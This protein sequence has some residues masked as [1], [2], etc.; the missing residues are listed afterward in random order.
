MKLPELDNPQRYEGLYIFDFQGQIGV[1]YTAREIEILLESEKYRDGKVYKIHRACP[2]GR[3]EIKGISNQV[4]QAE[5]G[6]FFY[7]CDQQQVRKDYQDLLELAQAGQF[8]CRAK[9]HL[10]RVESQQ[11]TKY[12]VALIYPAEYEED[13][14]AWLLRIGYSGGESVSGGSSQVAD[15]YA[16]YEKINSFQLWGVLDGTTRDADQVLAD[17]G[18]AVV[19]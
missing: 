10:S 5:S 6:M 16:H 18:R 3:L 14:S 11:E 8:P 13:V 9:L 2:D 15:Y 19:R 1:G 7:G 12:V 4:F 17:V